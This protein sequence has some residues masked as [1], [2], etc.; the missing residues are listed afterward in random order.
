MSFG[1]NQAI[2]LRGQVPHLTVCRPVMKCHCC[3]VVKCFVQVVCD[4]GCINHTG[5]KQTQAISITHSRSKP[6]R[7]YYLDHNMQMYLN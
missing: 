7:S 1:H 4:I 2:A 5:Q 3:Q 6:R